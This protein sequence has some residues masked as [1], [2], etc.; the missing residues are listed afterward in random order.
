MY[1]LIL[2][3]CMCV[4]VCVCDVY[5]WGVVCMCVGLNVVNCNLLKK[6]KKQTL[7]VL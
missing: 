2:C 1:V 5:V 3:A 7:Q 6:N 4:Y